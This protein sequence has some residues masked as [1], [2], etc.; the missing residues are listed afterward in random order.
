[1]QRPTDLYPYKHRLNEL[2]G[3]GTNAASGNV[4]THVICGCA[5]SQETMP[6]FGQLIAE[7]R[8]VKGW[9]QKELAARII[10]EDGSPISPQYLNDIERDRR[11]A[12]SDYLISCFASELGLELDLLYYTAGEITPDLR[13]LDLPEHQVLGAFAAFRKNLEGIDG[14]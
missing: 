3:M 6:T 5:D 14:S 4:V 12:P 7:G 11:G 9:S 13:D 10:K 2:M 1:M 8:K